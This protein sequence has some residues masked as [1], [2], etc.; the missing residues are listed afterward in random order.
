MANRKSSRAFQRATD[1]V[2]MLPL[3]LERM[4]QKA[5]FGDP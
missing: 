5:I 2:H 3:S 4:A 1:G